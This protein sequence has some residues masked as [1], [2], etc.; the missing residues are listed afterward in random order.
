[1]MEFPEKTEQRNRLNDAK[2]LYLQQHK[3]NPVHWWSYRPEALAE[4]KKKDWPIFLSVGYSSCHWCH[5]MAHQSFEDQKIA[6]FLNKNFICIKVDREE[7]PDLDHYFQQACQI[8]VKSSGWPL[9]AFLLPDLRPFFV[10]TYF[11][12]ERTLQAN[13][14]TFGEL[15]REMSRAYHKD[16]ARVETSATQVTEALKKGIIQP[17]KVEYPHHF[18]APQA[19]FSAIA[20][21]CDQQCGGF[22]EA[23]KFPHF[24]FYEFALEQM[25][26]GM[27]NKEAGTHI[28][29]SLNNMLMGGIVDHPRG[30]I[31]RYSTDREFLI[32]HFEKMLYDQAGFL[33]VLVKLAIL[34]P[35]PLVHDTL[36]NTLEYLSCEMFSEDGYFF[37]AQDADSEGREGLYFTYSEEEFSTIVSDIGVKVEDAKSWFRIGK[38]GNFEDGLNVI[39]LNPLRAKEFFTPDNW[40]MIRRI[41]RSIL[42]NRQNRIPPATDNKGVASWNF[43]MISALADVIQYCRIDLIRNKARHLFDRAMEGLYRNFL[44]KDKTIRHATTIKDCHSPLLEDY[45]NLAEAQLRTYEITANPIFKEELQKSLKFILKEFVSSEGKLLTRS[46][47]S[48]QDQ[49]YPNQEVSSFDSS[50]KSEASTLIATARRSAVLFNDPEIQQKLAEAHK[51]LKDY[52]LM[53]PVNSGEALRASVYPDAAYKVIKIPAGWR[54]RGEF[55]D[56]YHSI[57]PRSIMDYHFDKKESWQICNLKQCELQGVGLEEFI[58]AV[59][60]KKGKSNST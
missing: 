20:E 1:M 12:K 27:V 54:E 43:Q 41:N 30:G 10:G 15:I 38:D 40:E 58:K 37:S 39:S 48:E 31:H 18:P 34:N 42:K 55:I 60:Q 26:E 17:Q 3:D 49:P 11:P 4:A 46:L 2:S 7:H 47:Q 53:N 14:I 29:K 51:R 16:R 52:A 57:L 23:P 32:P 6:D 25:M 9:S 8:F 59:S 5:V 22:G 24:S 50:F 33:R 56:F 13:I 19:I 28:I 44:N 35:S 45:A 21:I 36:L